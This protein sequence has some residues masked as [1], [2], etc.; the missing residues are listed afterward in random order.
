MFFL[1]DEFYVKIIL[2]IDDFYSFCP[3]Q[4]LFLLHHFCLQNYLLKH[5]NSSIL[6]HFPLFNPDL[7]PS[8]YYLCIKFRCVPAKR[9]QRSV[10]PSA[11]GGDIKKDC[12]VVRHS[13]LVGDLGG[14]RTLDPMIK[15]HLLYQLSYQVSIS[16]AKLHHLFI[17][18]NILPNFFSNIFH[19]PPLDSTNKARWLLT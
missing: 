16:G 6:R 4:P 3:A 10:R 2:Q 19:N 14:A 12:V 18:C 1:I 8:R 5:R 13:L 7:T 9:T 11:R 17:L 15:S